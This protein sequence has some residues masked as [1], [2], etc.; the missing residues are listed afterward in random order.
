[1]EVLR[2]ADGNASPWPLIEGRLC[3]RFHC[4]PWE[5][6][7]HDISRLFADRDAVDLYDALRKM[8]R[9]ERLTDYENIIVGRALELEL[10]N[11]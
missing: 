6:D 3:E 9:G 1:L 2:A 11:G 5:L 4:L 8:Q 7:G 10:E